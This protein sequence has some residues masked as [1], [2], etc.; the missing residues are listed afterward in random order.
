[1][2]ELMEEKI[3]HKIQLSLDPGPQGP[4]TF[5]SPDQPTGKVCLFSLGMA[6]QT[7]FCAQMSV[8]L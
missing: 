7:C 8:Q 5:S 3:L 2:N 1:M 6:V 4:L